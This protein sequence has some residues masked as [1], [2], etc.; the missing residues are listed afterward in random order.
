MQNKSYWNWK[1]DKAHD[2]DKYLINQGDK[3]TISIHKTS[4]QKGN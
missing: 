3:F 4:S 2:K 1:K